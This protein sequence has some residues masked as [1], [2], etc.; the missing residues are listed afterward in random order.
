MR[1]DKK[2]FDLIGFGSGTLPYREPESKSPNEA[3]DGSF[4]RDA[5]LWL[6]AQ[7]MRPPDEMVFPNMY[8][9]MIDDYVE[10]GES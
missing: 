8:Q 3:E 7:G 4:V 6:E 10:S 5:E 9:G 1:I 2:F